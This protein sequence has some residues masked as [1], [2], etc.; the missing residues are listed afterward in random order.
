MI[1]I[2]VNGNGVDVEKVAAIIASKKKAVSAY[3]DTRIAVMMAI[4]TFLTQSRQ[5]FTAKE[6]SERFGL[7]IGVIA[8]VARDYGIWTRDRK[9]TNRYVRL[10]DCGEVDLDD[11]KEFT[12]KCK[13]YYVPTY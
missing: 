3:E 4:K 6:L 9:T 13:E 10:T 2:T 5:G 12:Y 7:P 8:R 1:T 11:I